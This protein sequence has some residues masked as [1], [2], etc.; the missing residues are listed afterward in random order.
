MKNTTEIAVLI[1]SYNP[2][3][4]LTDTLNSLRKQT[5]PYHLYI[6]DDGSPQKPD[7][8]AELKGIPHSLIELP[9]NAG[10]TG[11]LNAGL[12]QIFREG[13]VYV[14]RMDCGDEMTEDRLAVQKS[15]MDQHPEIS[16][17]GS[18]IEMIYTEKAGSS[19]WNGRAATTTSCAVCGRTCRSPIRR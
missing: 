12:A 11:A 15:F 2:G 7:Y 14:A 9:R 3:S 8:A 19:R 13:H 16:I 1:P 6:V 4:G 5:V 18:W 17:L 10:I